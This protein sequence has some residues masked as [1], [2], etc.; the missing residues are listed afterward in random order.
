MNKFKKRAVSALV[1]AI[2]L[3]SVS[4]LTLSN[5]NAEINLDDQKT[6]NY[7]KDGKWHDDNFVNGYFARQCQ[8]F[9]IM[10][11]HK[12]KGG[13]PSNDNNNNKARV[14]ERKYKLESIWDLKEGDIVRYCITK[15]K[16][17]SVHSIFIIKMN[18]DNNEIR[19]ADANYDNNNGIRWSEPMDD[20][21]RNRIIDSI[22]NEGTNEYPTY[23][24]R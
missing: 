20:S 4:S 2:S 6:E 24:W 7:C 12:K 19:F 15:G 16:E 22:N 1:S 10:M 17:R 23:F 11:K 3:F 5:A 9:A 13:L 8:A 21:L 18:K 14:W